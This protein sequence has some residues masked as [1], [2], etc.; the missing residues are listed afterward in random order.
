MDDLQISFR[1][2]AKV[3]LIRVN[4]TQVE[5]FLLPSREIEQVKRHLLIRDHF[6]VLNRV[7]DIPP[8]LLQ[9]HIILE[10][11]ETLPSHDSSAA[12]RLRYKFH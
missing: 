12:E 11:A 1:E 2:T 8:L 9:L 4:V 6:K 5:V 7:P 10:Q 3:T